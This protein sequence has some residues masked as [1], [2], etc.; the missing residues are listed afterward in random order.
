M[1]KLITLLL[2][3]ILLTG[4]SVV[5]LNNK[6]IEL[7]DEARTE[8]EQKVQEYTDLII[9]YEPS[10]EE[11]EREIGVAP[12]DGTDAKFIVTTEEKADERPPASY[13]AQKARYERYLG[14]VADA[15]ITL[16]EGLKLYDIS[17]VLWGNL[18]NLYELEKEYEAAFTY[19][20]KVLKTFPA[21]VEFRKK[22]LNMLIK[23]DRLEEARSLYNEFNSKNGFA[24]ESI[25]KKIN[26]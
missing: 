3:A 20:Q 6:D 26:Q 9:N 11:T 12:I 23:L 19:Y 2:A 21:R 24:D 17:S 14:H 18:G 7:S 8:Y 5:Q 1:K 16:K 15:E 25:R 22:A 4:C 13:F 10:E